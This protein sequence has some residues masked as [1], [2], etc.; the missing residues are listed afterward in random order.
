MNNEIV[1]YTVMKKY[2]TENW[3]LTFISLTRMTDIQPEIQM[4]PPPPP[5]LSHDLLGVWCDN[6][7]LHTPNK[8]RV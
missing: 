4:P 3:E 7:E 8:K 2:V 5:V 6:F 1:T